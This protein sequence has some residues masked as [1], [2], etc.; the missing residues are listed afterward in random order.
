MAKVNS[1]RGEELGS[2]PH[3]KGRE[4]LPV[5]TPR[6]PTAVPPCSGSHTAPPVKKSWPLPSPP[7]SHQLCSSVG[8]DVASRAP[9]IARWAENK[10]WNSGLSCSHCSPD[11]TPCLPPNNPQF[12]Q[13][14]ICFG[15]AR[16]SG[17][18]QRGSEG[19]SAESQSPPCLHREHQPPASPGSF[20]TV[21]NAGMRNL[22]S[23]SPL[24]AP[25]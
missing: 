6:A 11:M 15:G 20:I 10:E 4:G 2:S 17:R 25:Q 12:L 3:P 23:L 7:D 21:I 14:Q 5:A 18:L 8:L 9:S 1:F 13:P 24:P 16:T 22:A 19:C